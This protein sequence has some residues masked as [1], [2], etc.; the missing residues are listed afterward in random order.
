MAGLT[1]RVRGEL[2]EREDLLDGR[3]LVQLE[4]DAGGW[5]VAASFGWRRGREGTIELDAAESALSIVDGARE[6][7]ASVESGTVTV[8]DDSGGV[9]VL[10]R[11]RVDEVRGDLAVPGGGLSID[12]TIDGERWSGELSLDGAAGEANGDG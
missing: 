9:R 5:A 4:G 10:A 2:S 11:L 3:V 12:C 6:L 8:D 1:R 7:H